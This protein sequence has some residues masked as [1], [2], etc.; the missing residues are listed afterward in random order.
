MPSQLFFDQANLAA[1]AAHRMFSNASLA[2]Q[3]RPQ[4]IALLQ[5]D[6]HIVASA[7]PGMAHHNA[8]MHPAHGAWL[9]FDPVMKSGVSGC[10]VNY[11]VRLK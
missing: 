10:Q 9:V 7:P 6:A 5:Q 1:T 8:V 11:F 4:I 3:S 2:G